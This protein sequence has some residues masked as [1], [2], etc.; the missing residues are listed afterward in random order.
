[1]LPAVHPWRACGTGA[2]L[3]ASLESAGFESRFEPRLGATVFR[4]VAA[5]FR[6]AGRLFVIAA[7]LARSVGM[8]FVRAADFAERLLVPLLAAASFFIAG[9]FSKRRTF[10]SDIAGAFRL[11]PW[12]G[13]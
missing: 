10:A 1:M 12:G 8:R 11:F 7:L 2:R 3:A 4:L 6:E 5:D 13:G 9:A